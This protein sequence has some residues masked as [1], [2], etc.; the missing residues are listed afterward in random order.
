MTK[1]SKRWAEGQT[2]WHRD[3]VNEHL[4]RH[5]SVLFEQPT[6]RILV[7]LCGCCLVGRAGQRLWALIWLSS[8]W[9]SSLLSV[10]CNQ[11]E[12]RSVVYLRCMQSQSAHSQRYFCGFIQRHWCL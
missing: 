6:P 9:S 3:A 4:Q 12:A 8:P 11:S 7:P 5:Q 2:G 10:D 1:W